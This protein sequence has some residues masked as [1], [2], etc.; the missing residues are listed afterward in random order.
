MQ[1][2]IEISNNQLHFRS[3]EATIA[4]NN[5]VRFTDTFVEISR[6]KQLVLVQKKE[7]L[8]SSSYSSK[9]VTITP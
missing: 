1:K 3:L 6:S 8:K 9:K 7:D 5:P 2:F 4:Q